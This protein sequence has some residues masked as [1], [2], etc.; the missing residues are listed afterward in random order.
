MT[1]IEVKTFQ[2]RRKMVDMEG[3]MPIQNFGR[4]EAQNMEEYINILF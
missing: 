2:G 4:S 1:S 3:H